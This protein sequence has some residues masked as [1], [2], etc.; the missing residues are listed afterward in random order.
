MHNRCKNAASLTIEANHP[1][2]VNRVL[3]TASCKVGVKLN[4]LVKFQTLHHIDFLHNFVFSQSLALYE[5]T[6]DDFDL[7]QVWM[8][9]STNPLIK[10]LIQEP[11]P[12][13]E[14]PS[15]I[16]IIFTTGQAVIAPQQH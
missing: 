2:M 4:N 9:H 7:V 13:F 3:F 15:L 16:H 14:R 11:E 6:L 10:L 8:R 5:A 1:V 12:N